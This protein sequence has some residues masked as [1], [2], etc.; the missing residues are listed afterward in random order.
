MAW[1]EGEHR[2]SVTVAADRDR[3]R[4]FF[5]DPEAILAHSKDVESS[6]VEGETIHFVIKLQDHGVMKFQG[7]FACRYHAPDEA[8]VRWEP[9]GEGNTKQSGEAVFTAL[10][11]GGTRIDYRERVAIDLDV[12]GMMAPMLKPVV[13]PMVTYEIKEYLRRMTAAL[14]AG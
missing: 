11:G 12:P 5:A 8:T 13:G 3:A 14:D 10:P 2:E 1:F 7:R 4:A 6:R 9:V